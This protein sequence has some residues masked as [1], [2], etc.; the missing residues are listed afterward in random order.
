MAD[1]LQAITIRLFSSADQIAAKKLIQ[2]G[3]GDRFG[4]IDDT[5][6]PDINDISASYLEQGAVFIVAELDRQLVGT[7]ALIQE[8]AVAGR[9]VRVSVDKKY[10]GRGLGQFITEYLIENGRMLGYQ[11][12]LVE[13]NEDWHDAIHLYKR[14]GFQQV[15]QRNS[16]IHMQ[17][18]LK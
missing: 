10:R 17:L 5:L 13:T 8:T 12:I 16:E 14:C 18:K 4:F 6:N 3:L 9:I 15:D 11:Q 7:G 1:L 2:A